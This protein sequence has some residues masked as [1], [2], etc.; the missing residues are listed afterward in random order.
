MAFQD[1]AREL[2]MQFFNDKTN[3]TKIDHIKYT[4]FACLQA[5]ARSERIHLLILPAGRLR[6]PW[7]KVRVSA[8]GLGASGLSGVGSARRIDQ[9]LAA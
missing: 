7:K 5:S 3:Y 2:F 1:R 6:S 8:R 9:A 4:V